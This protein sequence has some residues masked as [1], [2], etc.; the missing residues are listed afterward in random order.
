MDVRINTEE[1]FFDIKNKSHYEVSSI[2]DVNLRYI[3]EAGTENTHEIYRC[4]VDAEALV[5]LMCGKFVSSVQEDIQEPSS[6]TDPAEATAE[7]E[8]TASNKH[9]NS[10]P[11]NV[12]TGFVYTFIDNP[13]RQDNR[14]QVLANSIHSAIVSM[15]LSKFYVSVNQMELS[16]AHDALAK[17]AVVLLE[18]MLYE[19]K[20]PSAPVWNEPTTN[21]DLNS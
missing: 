11:D 7:G 6:P 8:E 20:Q 4:I 13:R 9:N 3:A 5:R 10:L 18:R 14:G 19:K 2:Q 16:Q 12:P 15:A 1:L 17:N 21:P